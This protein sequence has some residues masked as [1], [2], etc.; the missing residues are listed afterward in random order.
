MKKLF[1][2]ICIATLAMSLN[3]CYWIEH[4]GDPTPSA[5]YSSTQDDGSGENPKSESTTEKDTTKKD[6]Q[7]I[8]I[9]EEAKK[10]VS[11]VKSDLTKQKNDIDSIKSELSAV[12]S[13]S[14]D[15]MDSTSAYT[16]MFVEAIIF[17]CLLA[18][19]LRKISKLN[20]RLRRHREDIEKI[21]QGANTSSNI[22][23]NSTSS[24]S[25]RDFKDLKT[26]VNNIE[27]R[28]AALDKKLNESLGYTP[29]QTQP[30]TSK[31]NNQEPSQ[32]ETPQSTNPK[33]FYMPRSPRASQF[34]DKQK[35]FTPSEGTYFKFTLISKDEA[36]FEFY[37]GEDTRKVRDS[38]NDRNDSI[39]TVCDIVETVSDPQ[40]CVTR[41][42][43]KAKLIGGIWYVNPKAKI[44]YV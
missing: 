2:I 15:K 26:K 1:H 24:V 6:S 33:V 8:N 12:S 3:S 43:G 14:E 37:G 27:V 17:L 18:Y 30:G 34:D 19:L 44:A 5:T 20:E 36:E 25:S 32:K 21:K 42:K 4:L 29:P 11:L 39:A 41:D 35:S 7:Q 23:T 28:V 31:P 16:F 40:R 13:A 38:F 10:Q 9:V 22:V